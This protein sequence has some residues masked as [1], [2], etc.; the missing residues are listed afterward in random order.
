MNGSC[1]GLKGLSTA[2]ILFSTKKKKRQLVVAPCVNQVWPCLDVRVELGK[3]S[4]LDLSVVATCQSHSSH[5]KAQSSLKATENHS[6]E[7]FAWIELVRKAVSDLKIIFYFLVKPQI[8]MCWIWNRLWL[9]MKKETGC[10]NNNNSR[11]VAGLSICF[12]LSEAQKR[13][14]GCSL[15]EAR[16]LL[17]NPHH[18][19]GYT[20]PRGAVWFVPPACIAL[21][22]QILRQK[23]HKAPGY[24]CKSTSLD[25]YLFLGLRLPSWSSISVECESTICLL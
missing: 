21:Q 18:S 5:A 24:K 12:S 3:I 17:H 16:T 25:L 11:G 15:H 22:Y 10:K 14:W 9:E 7:M 6:N 8:T 23:I 4:W 13:P 1:L 2:G 19:P 20:G